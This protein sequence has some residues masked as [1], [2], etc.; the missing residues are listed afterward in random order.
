MRK[1]FLLILC[2][3]TFSGFRIYSKDYLK[4][5]D[6]IISERSKYE[7]SKQTEIAESWA[8]YSAARTDSD[9]YNALRNLYKDYRTFR[10]DS[11]IIIADKRLEIARK[12]GM[13]SKIASASLNLAESYVKS[14]LADKA[15]QILD[16]LDAASLEDYH[17]KYRN[18]VYRYVYTLKAKTEM[19]PSDRIRAMEKLKQ[20]RDSALAEST[21]DSRSYHV[22]QAER[23][24]DAGMPQEAVAKIEEA[25]RI[26]DFS[27]DA[28][29]QYTMGEIYLR[30]GM[31]QEAKECLS[32]AAILDLSSGS[33]E[34]RA[35]I[36]LSSLLFDEGDVERAFVYINCAFEDIHFSNA[37]FRNPEIMENMPVIDTA[38]HAYEKKNIRLTRTFLWIA[39]ALVLL[40]GLMLGALFKVHRSNRRVMAANEEINA[41]LQAHNDRLKD[42]D[43]LKLRN[44]N[45][46]IMSNAR[47]IDRLE[48]YRKE[49]YRLVRT[50]QYE[51]ALDA[52]KSERNNSK[53]INTFHEMFD[54]T[55]I[56][57]FPDFV[58]D[59]NK[60][61]KEPVELK[62]PGRLTPELRVIALM[63]LGFTSTDDISRI[64][65]Y[66]SQTVY[67]LRSS[68]RNMSK[69]PRE[70]FE[71]EI[72]EL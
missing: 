7:N 3:L 44:I 43:L 52:L 53:D 18:S 58:S 68:I 1:I 55:F 41:R 47:Y 14:G 23:F 12:W 63:R 54:E 11:A 15:L 20:L 66:S 28:A 42:A 26:F 8:D 29:M 27:D 4:E 2:F 19:L 61:L 71:R 56:S 72:R 40:L 46:L 13:K 67:N 32:R 30:A 16:T 59:V 34:Y 60:L 38:F 35:L 9:R 48:N 70:E 65:Q 24:I 39:G 51:K 31:K 17:Q 25:D 64:L 5:L 21:P 37:N 69:L 49:V 10:I 57:M 45:T 22:I 36:L 62:E 50:N 6:L 33:K